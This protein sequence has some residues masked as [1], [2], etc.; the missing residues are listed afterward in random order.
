MKEMNHRRKIFWL[1][2]KKYL[3]RDYSTHLYS[4]IQ[5]ATE[6]NLNV[7]AQTTSARKFYAA[8]VASFQTSDKKTCLTTIQVVLSQVL[9]EDNLKNELFW[10]QVASQNIEERSSCVYMF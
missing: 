4:K 8:S 7:N 3:H 2:K 9:N 5:Q 1:W 6:I 10:D